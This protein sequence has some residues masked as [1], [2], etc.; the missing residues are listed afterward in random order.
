MSKV[1]IVKRGFNLY[2]KLG[3]RLFIFR[4]FQKLIFSYIRFSNKR[5]L[6][7]VTNETKNIIKE[8]NGSKMRFDTTMD[9]GLCRF[10]TITDVREYYITETMKNELKKGDIVVDIG[11]NVG[12]YA[13]LESKIVGNE[14]KIYAIEPV[15]DTIGLLKD[16]IR[17]NN[18]RNIEIYQLAIGDKIGTASMYVSKWRNRSQM[19]EVGI[20]SEIISHEIKTPVL[21]LDD[22]LKDKPFPTAVRMDV[23]GYEYNIIRGMKNILEND[24]PLKLFIEFHFRWLG[25]EKCFELLS[26]L[27]SAGF[28]IAVAAYELDEKCICKNKLLGNIAAYLNSKVS[29]L[30]LKG[31]LDLHIDDILSNAVVW[32]NKEGVLDLCLRFG[33]LE[34]L[35]EREEIK[36]K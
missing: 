4:I 35:F 31:Y 30:P 7:K 34:I 11:A 10:M 36:K 18:Y 13:L 2:N 26:I 33:T 24:L 17:L 3:L 5:I 20:K 1:S 32:G 16:N 14:G 21:T 6:S 25:K 23:E 22:F 27:K 15:P 28:K 19:K 29:N 12:Y 8:I 9:D